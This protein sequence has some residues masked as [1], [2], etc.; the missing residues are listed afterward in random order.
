MRACFMVEGGWS[1][2]TFQSLIKCCGPQS[3]SEYIW[4]ESPWSQ[5]FSLLFYLYNLLFERPISWVRIAQGPLPHLHNG[6]APIRISLRRPRC[7]RAHFHS[8]ITIFPSVALCL[9]AQ[10]FRHTQTHTHTQCTHRIVASHRIS[11][12]TKLYSSWPPTH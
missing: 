5:F 9:L 11:E 10:R 3:R 7:N 6:S 1:H 4:M 12:C 2:K 8:I